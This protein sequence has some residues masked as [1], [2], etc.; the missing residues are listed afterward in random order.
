[1]KLIWVVSVF[2]LGTPLGMAQLSSQGADQK[3]LT[4]LEQQMAQM[5]VKGRYSDQFIQDHLGRDLISVWPMGFEG[6][7]D[8]A[9]PDPQ[10]PLEE[11][12][13]NLR[14]TLYG[15][16]AIVEGTWAKKMKDSSDPAKTQNYRGFFMH[17]WVRRDMKWRLVRSAAGPLAPMATLKALVD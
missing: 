10:P 2:L 13:E 5:D 8:A 4:S 17:V 9:K 15:D 16:T 3:E 14:V 12:A 11:K 1:M 6:I 7:D